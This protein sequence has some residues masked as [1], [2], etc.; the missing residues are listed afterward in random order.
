MIVPGPDTTTI[1][2]NP[3]AGNSFGI[4][5]PWRDY[6]WNFRDLFYDR[7]FMV[8]ISPPVLNTDNT[9]VYTF[10][11]NGGTT[12]TNG[13]QTAGLWT[14]PFIYLRIVSLAFSI[15]PRCYII[16]DP[17]KVVLRCFV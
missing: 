12:D 10:E 17:S 11:D 14:K 8:N 4:F 2:E 7:G 3:G 9:V 6:V 15:L 5:G 13:R 1:K 16:I